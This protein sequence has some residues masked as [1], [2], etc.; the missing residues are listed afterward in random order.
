MTPQH[1][2]QV[3]QLFQSALQYPPHGRAAFLD[4]ACVSDP[5]LRSEVE[6]LISSHE[7]VGDS[8]ESLAGGLTA[9]MLAGDRVLSLIGQ[10]I[11][12]Y[13][14]LSHIGNGGMGD[15]YLAQDL[16]LDRRVALKLPPQEFVQNQDRMRRFRQEARAVSALNHPN[17]LTIH[18]VGQIDS[19]SFIAAEFIEGETLRAHM[20]REKLEIR[21]AVSIAIQITSALAAAHKA[22]IVHRDVKP[23]N[24]MLRDDGIVKVLDFGLAKLLH[25]PLSTSDTE[26]HTLANLATDPGTMMGTV[27]YMSP[28]QARGLEV[29]EC[30][31]IFSLGVLLYEMITG[32]RPFEGDTSSDVIAALL[33]KQSSPMVSHVGGVPAELERIVRKCL[34]KACENR[35]RSAEALLNDLEHIRRDIDLGVAAAENETRNSQQSPFQT[36]PLIVFLIV[37]ALTIVGEA[38]YLRGIWGAH[39]SAPA[40]MR[41]PRPSVDSIAVLPLLEAGTH[42][43]TDYLTDAFTD[44]LIRSLSHIPKLKVIARASVVRYKNRVVDAQSVG[45]DLGVSAVL[46]G[47]LVQR[48]D[49]VSISVE[50]MDARDNSYLWGQRYER[51]LT[52]LLSVQ[53]EISREVSKKVTPGLT[54]EAREQLASNHTG[55]AEAYQIY[56]KGQHFL[57]RNDEASIQR[58]R[59]YFQQAIEKDPGYALAYTGLAD[60]YI[61][62]P[63]PSNARQAKEAVLKALEIDNSLGEAHISLASILWHSEWDFAGAEPEFRRGI[64][65]NPGYASA[66]HDYSHYLMTIGRVEESLAESKRYLELDPLS[67]PGN[68]HMGWYYLTVRQ[69]DQAIYWEQKALAMDT[70]FRNARFQLG[71][72]FYHKGMFDE[73]VGEYLKAGVLSGAPPKLIETLREAY[74][75]L[76]ITGFLKR[77]L[78]E[79]RQSKERLIPL[80]PRSHIVAK[81]YGRLGAR[82]RSMECIEKAFENRDLVVD[83]LGTEPDFDGLRSDLRFTSLL[84]RIGLPAQ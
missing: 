78:S 26:E 7:Q 54:T 21:E 45:R 20:Q 60:T 32:R 69:Y 2:Q 14:I 51:K 59:E 66:H 67:P 39:A 44:S 77:W 55:N 16:R 62:Q 82:N 28:E 9:Q 48:G 37:A 1:W 29:D 70:N 12:P 24:I 23:E 63:D 13:K 49:G 41:S 75:K 84:R 17:I 6:S 34:E 27:N 74:T 50:L 42:P 65:L 36:R 19:L 58:A 11:G 5:T 83:A 30:T 76:H 43:D 81:L 33:T 71:E 31:D 61:D 57:E 80:F 15:V 18:E 64:E 72:A 52:D 68:V 22:G 47:R 25:R 4:E 46:T 53:R 3:K 35:Y 56:L 79:E 10:E 40:Q 38:I 8:I 73:A